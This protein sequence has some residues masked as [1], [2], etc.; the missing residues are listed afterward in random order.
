MEVAKKYARWIDALRTTKHMQSRGMMH[1]GRG[2]CVYGIME[3]ELYG[4]LFTPGPSGLPLQ[5]EFA[6][7]DSLGMNLEPHLTRIREM[8]LDLE[9][10][11]EELWNACG[12]F[13]P[14]V[15]ST[16]RLDLLGQMNDAGVPFKQIAD[17]MDKCQWGCAPPPITYPSAI[18]RLYRRGAI[19]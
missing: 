3:L 8:R 6:W 19:A 11:E 16:S 14:K 18:A 10:T 7:N 17:F 5:D 4:E 15:W 1:D 12:V 2:Y 9:P 13:T